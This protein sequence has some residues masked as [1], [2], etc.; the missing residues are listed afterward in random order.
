MH[1]RGFYKK[2]LSIDM[3]NITQL[4]NIVKFN[5]VLLILSIES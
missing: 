3:Y 4:N 5:L 2:H 1:A